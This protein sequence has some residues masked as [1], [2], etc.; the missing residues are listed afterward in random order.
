MTPTGCRTDELQTP[1]LPSSAHITAKV[2]FD[3]TVLSQAELPPTATLSLTI[4]ISVIPVKQFPASSRLISQ[5]PGNKFS[6]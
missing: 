5:L 1:L 3:T 2:T 4:W 6:T